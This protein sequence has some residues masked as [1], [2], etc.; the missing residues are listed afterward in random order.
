M[1][2][3]T[4]VDAVILVDATN[5]FNYLNRQAALRNIQ[6]LC[7][8]FSTILINTYREN[9][10]L[11]IGGSVLHSEEGTTQ[12]DQL[13]MPMYALG[14]IPMINCLGGSSVQQIWYADDA[15]ACGSVKA[16][17]SWWDKLTSVGPGYGYFLILLKLALL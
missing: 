5:A 6:H 4:D 2:S 11:Y 7:P 1:F 15:T 3:S 14:V 12:G 10:N 13:A 8:P 9:V 16:L 17:R